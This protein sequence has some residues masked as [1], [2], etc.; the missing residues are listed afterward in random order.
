M[1]VPTRQEGTTPEPSAA[2]TI[3]NASS[4][5]SGRMYGKTNISP[6]L[7]GITRGA[8]Y[9]FMGNAFLE[10]LK[11]T[12]INASPHALEEVA[13]GVVHPVTKETITKYKQLITDPLLR[14]TWS[15]AMCKELGR[16][17]QGFGKTEG[18]DTMRCLD[19]DGIK[20][21]LRDRV[22][23][24]ARIVVDY[25]PQKEDP[26]RVRITA[27]GNLIQYP[28]ELPTRTADL[29]ASKI[30]WNITIITRD[31]RYMVADAGN[32]YLATPMERKEYLQISRVDPPRIHG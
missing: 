32:F 9:Q 2:P 8:L 15:K 28:G 10:E 22:V 25:R 18:T 19:L 11:R 5:C 29:C 24:Y 21:I 14:E 6:P 3:E 17:C 4:R 30:M 16:L 23:T 7:A 31:A 26:N 27:G 12:K 13:N 20:C 1:P